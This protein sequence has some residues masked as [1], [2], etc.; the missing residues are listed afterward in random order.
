MCVCLQHY[1]FPQ[2]FAGGTPYPSAPMWLHKDIGQMQAAVPP[3]PFTK[4]PRLAYM[5]LRLGVTE[6]VHG[7]QNFT[8]LA[9]EL[10]LRNISLFATT[11]ESEGARGLNELRSDHCTPQFPEDGEP[12]AINY[13]PHLRKA[14]YMILPTFWPSSGQFIAEAAIYD[15]IVLSRP[16]RLF[17]KLLYPSFCAISSLEEALWKIDML[18]NDAFLREQILEHARRHRHLVDFAA[19]PTA[20]DLLKRIERFNPSTVLPVLEPEDYFQ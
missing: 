14:R 17:F 4:R 13:L 3:L 8:W 15:I 16:H 5:E 2:S 18:E 19:A 6:F 9:E 7:G 10:H 12:H 1:R 11:C 20:Q